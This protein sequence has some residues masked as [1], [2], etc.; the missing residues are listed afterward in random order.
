M[1]L[2]GIT[3]ML[4][5]G[6]GAVVE[7]LVENAGFKHLYVTD[8]MKDVA[9]GRGIVPDRNTYHDIA[10]EFRGK[11]PTALVEAVLENAGDESEKIILEA[12]HTVPEVN[13]IKEKGGVVI[14]VDADIKTRYKRIQ[15]RGGD[16]DNVSYEEFERLQKIELSS[17]DPNK[18]NLASALKEADFYIENN[19]TLEELHSKIDEILKKIET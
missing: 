11:G 1:T 3:G 7:Y 9:E 5:A 18:N 10:N 4:G 16:K 15:G 2:I 14:G 13:F 12:L 8:F 17:D 6:K 19:G